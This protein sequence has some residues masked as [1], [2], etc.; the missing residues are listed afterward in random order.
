MNMYIFYTPDISTTDEYFLNEEESH[1]CVKVLRMKPG[2]EVILVDGTGGYYEALLQ[3]TRLKHCKIKIKKK[4]ANYGKRDFYLHLAISPT[5]NI[6]R[7]EWFLEK[8]TEI[9][10]DE[11][12]PIICNH[13]ERKKIKTER[14]EKIIIAS[15]KQSVKAYKPVL[16]PLV[17]FASFIN[18]TYS[19]E[20]YIAHCQNTPKNYLKN[21]YTKGH[22]ALILIGPEGDFSQHEIEK[23]Q[24][25]GYTEITMGQERL[26]TETAGVLACHS[27]HLIN[28]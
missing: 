28:Q 26:R 15:M 5:K 4:I 10:I 19:Q 12:T 6:N 17:D 18:Q 20:C 14:L 3:E 22:G 7:F 8:A 1:H 27:I 16:N 21:T 11:I 23:A 25:N 2:Q 24:N 9:G 13:S